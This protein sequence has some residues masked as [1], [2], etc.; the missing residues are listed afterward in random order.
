MQIF[1]R[2]KVNTRHGD[3]FHR[4]I[5]MAC[6]RNDS[7]WSILLTLERVPRVH[8]PRVRLF[9]SY[10]IRNW[11]ILAPVP[12]KDRFIGLDIRRFLANMS[13]YAQNQSSKQAEWNRNWSLSR[14]NTYNW[15][16]RFNTQTTLEI[17]NNPLKWAYNI[18]ITWLLVLPV[19]VPEVFSASAGFVAKS[20]WLIKEG[21][22]LLCSLSRL[23][24]PPKAFIRE[25]FLEDTAD[26][27]TS[28]VSDFRS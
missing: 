24:F 20:W 1:G 10:H 26:H 21:E 7:L 17:E 12:Y 5:S 11:T 25:F 14:K 27:C 2:S 4:R 15:L 19:V 23:W 9:P 3:A 22:L 28:G 13:W 8:R 6:L 16:D 18:F